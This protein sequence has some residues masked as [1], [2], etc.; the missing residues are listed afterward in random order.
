VGD[1]VLRA[2]ASVLLETVRE[3][4]LAGR[5]GGEEFLVLLP[6]SDVD[7]A[8][9][10]AER[11]RL[12]LAGMPVTPPDGPAFTVTASFGVASHR[13]GGDVG[14]LYAAADEALYRAKA[15]GKDRVELARAV[16]SFS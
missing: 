15:A 11:I 14:T 5:W 7:G 10:L 12:A 3:S 16:R 4:D 9:Q 1:E 8:A 13:K 2:L 6:G